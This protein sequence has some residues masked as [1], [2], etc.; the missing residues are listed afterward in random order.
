MTLRSTFLPILLLAAGTAR[1]AV[2]LEEG[3]VYFVQELTEDDVFELQTLGS[4]T[5][6][7]FP[8]SG[9]GSGVAG[10]A[11]PGIVIRGS[12]SSSVFIV[13]PGGSVGS[14]SPALAIR[15]W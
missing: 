13:G 8:G 7:M 1:G 9:P 4:E 14:R 12:T 2:S 3:E 10:L 6:S 11:D 5:E 15:K